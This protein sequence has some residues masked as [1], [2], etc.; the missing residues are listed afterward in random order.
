[1]S[2]V[3]ATRS[4]RNTGGDNVPLTSGDLTITHRLPYDVVVTAGTTAQDVNRF[5]AGAW[6]WIKSKAGR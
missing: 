3:S 1:M 2:V 5:G 6:E 4:F